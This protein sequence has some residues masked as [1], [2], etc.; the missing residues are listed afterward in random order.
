MLHVVVATCF[1]P[2]ALL[3]ALGVVALPMWA[4]ML[5]AKVA[6]PERIAVDEPTWPILLSIGEVFAGVI[7]V[8]G[9]FRTLALLRKSATFRNRKITG[10]MVTIGLAGLSLFNW[11]VFVP[12]VFNDDDGAV[13]WLALTDY[14][15]LPYFGTACLVYATRKQLFAPWKSSTNVVPSA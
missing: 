1:A 10:L 5:V 13:P 9:L 12:G 7:G 8:I 15:A 3:L 6:Q 2:L 14:V 11:V 4:A